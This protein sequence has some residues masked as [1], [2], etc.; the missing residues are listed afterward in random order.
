MS[1]PGDSE[2]HQYPPTTAEWVTSPL[3]DHDELG[4]NP[5]EPVPEVKPS[6]RL[7][8]ALIII[9]GL[10]ALASL[11]VQLYLAKVIALLGSPSVRASDW[12]AIV[13]PIATTIFPLVFAVGGVV[14]GIT[15]RAHVTRRSVVQV[16]QFA[17]AGLALQLLTIPLAVFQIIAPRVRSGQTIGYVLGPANWLALASFLIMLAAAWFIRIVVKPPV[18]QEDINDEARYRSLVDRGSSRP[19]YNRQLPS[20]SSRR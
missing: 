14:R 3:P 11:I 1:S 18:T 12:I 16:L 2:V 19:D 20:R 17:S 4:H 8:A 7:S 13:F 6:V 9:S 5:L 15:L 10:V